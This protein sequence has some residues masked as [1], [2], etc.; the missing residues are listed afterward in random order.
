V[1][2]QSA[3]SLKLNQVVKSV[4]CGGSA[5]HA[6]VKVGMVLRA[7]Q[8]CNRIEFQKNRS[9]FHISPRHF[10]KVSSI[11]YF[12]FFVVGISFQGKPL[13]HFSHFFTGGPAGSYVLP[14]VFII[15]LHLE[16]LPFFRLKYRFMIP[17]AVALK[18]S[19][20]NFKLALDLDQKFWFI[21]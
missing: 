5:D 14:Q 7:V 13:S 17:K 2:E 19:S 6:G 11:V 12:S 18:I 8:G 9:P 1:T 10:F 21:I 4:T 20:S 15:C 16:F 3:H